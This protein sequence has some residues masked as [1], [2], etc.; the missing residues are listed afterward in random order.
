MISFAGIRPTQF[1]HVKCTSCTDRFTAEREEQNVQRG[2]VILAALAVPTVREI[3]AEHPTYRSGGSATDGTC[4]CIG[5]VI[6]ALRRAGGIWPGTHGSNYAARYEV[7]K[8][9]RVSSAADLRVGDLVL[10]KREPGEAGWNLPAA[11]AGHAD[12]RDYYHAG[13]VLSV[14]PLD[15]VHC[16]SPDTTAEVMIDGVKTKVKT[17]IRHDSK[18]GKWTYA[19]R[20]NKV[21][22]EG[23]EGNMSEA[24]YKA[25]VATQSG[26]LNIRDAPGQN[27]KVLAKAPKGTVLEV[28]A[29]GA[30]PR[31]RFGGIEGYASGAYLRRIDTPQEG[32]ADVS[33]ALTIIDDAGDRFV[34]VGG[35]RVVIGESVD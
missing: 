31:V 12:Q 2:G 6:G 20:L 22:Y 4:D 25:T 23:G 17:S 1:G 27:G 32:D 10:K 24:I 21:D 11:Y 29:E 34:P 28:L 5:L 33:G 3:D 35:F 19:A 18:L 30:W 14:S 16:T 7:D 8:L 26:P 9:R 15:I 13:V